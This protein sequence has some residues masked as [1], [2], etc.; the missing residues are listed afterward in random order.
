MKGH[1]S[2]S[3]D[4][5]ILKSAIKRL[6]EL[7]RYRDGGRSF[8]YD[9]GHCRA[10]YFYDDYDLAELDLEILKGENLINES[11]EKYIEIEEW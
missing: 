1:I 2:I 5:E 7:K 6:D 4:Y 10:D 3:G 8:D 9:C 11:N